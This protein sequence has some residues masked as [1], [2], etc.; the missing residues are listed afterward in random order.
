ML[1]KDLL[2]RKWLYWEYYFIG[3]FLFCDSLNSSILLYD[4]NNYEETQAYDCIYYDG[5]GAIFYNN[6]ESVQFIKYCLRPARF[7]SVQR[8]YSLGC[9]NEGK[10]ISF[11]VLKQYNITTQQLLQWK[12]G[13][14][15]IDRYRAYLANHQLG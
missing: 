13:V 10:L 3:L 12:S 15:T 5:G 11:E 2:K 1:L 7:V 9:L 14:S 6:M 4:T 8:N